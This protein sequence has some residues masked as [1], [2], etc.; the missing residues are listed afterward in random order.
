MSTIEKSIEWIKIFKNKWIEENVK[1]KILKKTLLKKLI[2]LELIL[3]NK[4]N[5]VEEE[6]KRSELLAD[7]SETSE[8]EESTKSLAKTTTTTT[9]N[10][11]KHQR[12]T[13]I[14][15]SEEEHYSSSKSKET[16]SETDSDG[17]FEDCVIR[18]KRVPDALAESSFPDITS[19][20]LSLRRRHHRQP[21]QS[22]ENGSSSNTPQVRKK[23]LKLATSTSDT[24]D[25]DNQK[26]KPKRKQRIESKS[27]TKSSLLLT[28]NEKQ[29]DVT[30][31]DKTE[32]H[33]KERLVSNSCD[34]D[35]ILCSPD[36][37]IDQTEHCSGLD[38]I[39]QNGRKLY[40]APSEEQEQ[41]VAITTPKENDKTPTSSEKENEHRNNVS[42]ST[43]TTTTDDDNL[44]DTLP[45]VYLK[46]NKQKSTTRRNSQSKKRSKDEKIKKRKEKESDIIKIHMNVD[47]Q[48]KIQDDDSNHSDMQQR[49]KQ[50]TNDINEEQITEQPTHV[51]DEVVTTTDE[52][53]EEIPLLVENQ[54]SHQSNDN[55]ELL[56][57]LTTMTTIASSITYSTAKD[58]EDIA[59]SSQ[60]INEQ[61]SDNAVVDSNPVD[62]DNLID[63][64]ERIP[65][66]AHLLHDRRLLS[67]S[68]S[69]ENMI[70]RGKNK[71]DSDDE[72]LTKKRQRKSDENDSQIKKTTIR[73]LTEKQYLSTSTSDDDDSNHSNNIRRHKKQLYKKKRVV[74]KR[75]SSSEKDESSDDNKRT[76]RKR[77][78]DNERK[79]L[80]KLIKKK[81]IQKNK[82]KKTEIDDNDLTDVDATTNNIQ[83][84]SDDESIS[85]TDDN[86]N[87]DD[88]KDDTESSTRK[89]R[90]N[91]RKIIKDKELQAQTKSAV[92][93]EKERRKRIE[94]KQKEYNEI[95]LS[96]S[97]YLDRNK[98][99]IN[100]KLIL[101]MNK[102]TNEP[103]IEVDPKLVK[104]M[105]QHQ[106]EGVQFLWNNLFESLEAINDKRHKTH[107]KTLQVISF[108]HTLFKHE[109]LTH[110]R[111]CLVLCPI[112]A[113]LNWSTEFEYWLENIEPKIDIYQITSMKLSAR[114]PQL[115]YWKEN[116]GVVIM[117]YEMYRR[118][119]N[120]IGIKKKQSK[121]KAQ[122][123]LVNPGPD[124]IVCDE[125][126]ILKNSQ[127]A[128]GKAVNQVKTARRVVLTGTPLQ[129]NL[130]EYFC[131]VNFIKPNLLGTQ[132]EFINRFVNPIQNGQHRDSNMD[133]VKLMKRRACVLHDLLTGC[134]DRRDYSLLKNYLPPKFEYIITIRM[135]DL[136]QTLYEMYLKREVD[137]QSTSVVSKKNFQST[138][139]FTDYQ[140]LMKIWTHPFILRPHFVDQYRRRLMNDLID[141]DEEFEAIFTD[142]DEENERRRKKKQSLKKQTDGIDEIEEIDIKTDNQRFRGFMID[143]IEDDV[144]LPEIDKDIT[145][146]HSKQKQRNAS[147]S[148]ATSL[149]LA[150]TT[151]S[152]VEE[153]NLDKYTKEHKSDENSCDEIVVR[154][155]TRSRAAYAN[156]TTENKSTTK[157]RL[158]TIHTNSDIFD[159]GGDNNVLANKIELNGNGVDVDN[160]TEDAPWMSEMRQQWWFPF[161]ND[162]DEF[163][164]Q[165]S[166]KMTILKSILEKCSEIGDKLLL[167]SRSLYTLNYI[168]KFLRHIHVENEKIYNDKLEKRR[169][170]VR[171]L[172]NGNGSEINC[173]DNE[174]QKS[175]IDISQIL[176]NIPE[177]VQWIKDID[178]FRMDGSTDVQL[179]KRYAKSFND[180]NNLR[181]RLFLISTLAGGVGINL[182]GSNRVIVFDAS[183]NPS[184]D[185]QAI[186]R[187]YRFGQT[188]PVYIYRFLA[189]GTMEEK[190]YQR[191]VIK[192]SLSQRV[193]DDH[194]LTR[195]FSEADLKELYNFTPKPLPPARSEQEIIDDVNFPIPKDHLLTDLLYQHNQWIHSYHSH[196]SLLE[197][198][199]D[200]GLSADEKKIAIEEYENLKKQPDNYQQRLIQ[201]RLQQQR[202]QEMIQ[203]QFL[204]MI[205]SSQNQAP[206]LLPSTTTDQHLLTAQDIFRQL[207]QNISEN[208]RSN[209]DME[210][211]AQYAYDQAIQLR[212]QRQMH[213][214]NNSNT[215][216]EQQRT[217]RPQTTDHQRLP[218]Q[219]RANRVRLNETIGSSSTTIDSQNLTTN[220]NNSNNNN[221]DI[222]LLGDS[223]DDK[224]SS[225]A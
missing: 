130:I 50:K 27:S 165:L 167:F 76:S 19:P 4:A 183:W 174:N 2:E 166:G 26:S 136:Q 73:R 140:Y 14:K 181:A 126:H 108:I 208:E 216:T 159:N 188:K 66:Y 171:L 105:K 98:N 84:N 13:L 182:I 67:S 102:E 115:N 184:V 70:L 139:L 57:P 123:C 122:E 210:K 118:L 29:V 225:V 41:I 17:I 95:L 11:E 127:T 177:S 5:N 42:S 121:L 156:T 59:T 71:L 147:S 23:I 113:A 43:V 209:V 189:H 190:I 132:Q 199:L 74:V 131:M 35:N 164:I 88:D 32:S 213:L 39:L 151:S 152:D 111:T 176:E 143:N 133:D 155:T 200:E 69:D 168:E 38:G 217:N 112:N 97:G 180:E 149:S 8:K 18:I 185:T 49:K 37:E 31:D 33:S 16:Q 103:L 61:N 93:A 219:R 195:H 34:T 207:L 211:V 158:T 110:I 89:G 99:D 52:Q 175:T 20:T 150:S 92:E 196:D 9:V 119:A 218:T 86:N 157:K 104:N 90:K 65:T 83:E 214:Q 144:E 109:N 212:H 154:R 153:I 47:E 135:C 94:Q 25:I 186:F 120:G 162:E 198:R 124:I 77:T 12:S 7:S 79:S 192:Q 114:I 51:C 62:E 169:E 224:D 202:L 160:E 75:S 173:T 81:T 55:E 221:G 68:S 91:I 220:P 54:S 193:I 148:T 40:K 46:K 78:R 197:N 172:E 116:G 206:S 100:K 203:H 58:T 1:N 45:I 60:Q 107:R 36:D 141:D 44:T 96:Q 146:T 82:K 24:S 223:D 129:N 161:M 15:D 64:R 194:Q 56:A 178:Y 163:N 80:L 30:E 142:E 3:E 222:I 22:S 204:T 87:N 117:G 21:T 170:L 145:S 205:G 101:E 48:D 138:K 128:L 191:Q 134:V 106:L 85:D 125:G 179:R 10:E 137:G 215:S 63:T 201:Q 6:Q 53:Q 72:P 187:S 28:N